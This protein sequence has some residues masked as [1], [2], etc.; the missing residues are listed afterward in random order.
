MESTTPNS[1]EGAQ[2]GLKDSDSGQWCGRLLH[3]VAP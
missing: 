3:Q 1:M 2:D